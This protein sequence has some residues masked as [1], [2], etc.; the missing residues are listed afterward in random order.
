MPIKNVYRMKLK[1]I[2]WILIGD[3]LSKDYS[4]IFVDSNM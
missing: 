4:V 1:L 3:S 2:I